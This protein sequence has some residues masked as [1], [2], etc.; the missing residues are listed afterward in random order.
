MK[1]RLS[2]LDSVLDLVFPTVSVW[3]RAWN[4]FVNENENRIPSQV[5]VVTFLNRRLVRARSLVTMPAFKQ[6]GLRTNK[7]CLHNVVREMLYYKVNDNRMDWSRRVLEALFFV[8][9]YPSSKVLLSRLV[10]TSILIR[11][12]DPHYFMQ[13]RH[14]IETLFVYRSV[15]TTSHSVGER[16]RRRIVGPHIQDLE[17]LSGN[18]WGTSSELMRQE[19]ETHHRLA[20]RQVYTWILCCQH[21]ELWSMLP[22]ELVLQV[23]EFVVMGKYYNV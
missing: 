19:A 13:V 5:G 15:D 8:L 11:E 9:E 22:F 1:G 20:V 6:E 10:T 12:H 18:Y 23:A 2:L 14:F 21:S 16:V 7:L 4:E 17:A 3:N